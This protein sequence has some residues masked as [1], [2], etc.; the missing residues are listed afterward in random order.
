MKVY[1]VIGVVRYD[2]MKHNHEHKHDEYAHEHSH[3]EQAHEHTHQHEGWDDGQGD[4]IAAMKGYKD[5]VNEHGRHFTDDLA[6]WASKQMKN[7]HGE[8][9][10]HWSVADVKSAFE[11]FGLSKPEDITWGD[12]AYSANMHYA[13]YFGQSLKSETDCV[14]QAY[15]DVTDPDGYTSKIFNRWFADVLGNKVNVPWDKF[16]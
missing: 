12:V 13:D 3:E 2:D 9:N 5:Y 6:T 10:H 1:R 14:K 8:P 15:A 7:A 11:R 16:I 4:T